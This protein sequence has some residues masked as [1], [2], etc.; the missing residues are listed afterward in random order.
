MEEGYFTLKILSLKGE[1][2]EGDVS[3]FSAKSLIGDFDILKN[4]IN[5]VSILLPGKIKY[6]EKALK[7]EAVI[8]ID[9]GIL[10]LTNNQAK[11][12]VNFT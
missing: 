9:N 3:H 12:F 10:V 8:T 6:L 2:F 4:H 11:V 1:L 7:E 5:F